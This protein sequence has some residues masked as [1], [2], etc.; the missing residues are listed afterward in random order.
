MIHSKMQEPQERHPE[1]IPGVTI[2]VSCQA[3]KS[4]QFIWR[5]G[6]RRWNLRV[7]DL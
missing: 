3:V 6:N 2:L 1:S 4:V 7:P 5:W